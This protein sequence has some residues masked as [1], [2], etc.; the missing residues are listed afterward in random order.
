MTLAASGDTQQVYTKA[1]L[2]ETPSI[3]PSIYKCV[4]A[5]LIEA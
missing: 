1:V 3:S 2:I 4:H 5:A